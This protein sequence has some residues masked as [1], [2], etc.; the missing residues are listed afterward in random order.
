[1]RE[2]TPPPSLAEPTFPLN[3]ADW[4]AMPV[5]L[6]LGLAAQIALAGGR[7]T[8]RSPLWTD[9]IISEWLG[10]D[11][12]LRHMVG[13]LRAG[14]DTNTPAFHLLLRATTAVVRHLER[15]RSPVG[16]FAL[17]A[18]LGPLGSLSDDS[19]RILP[20]SSSDDDGSRL[21]APSCSQ[22]CF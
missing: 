21:V 6:A 4:V 14:I 8:L 5:L 22:V 1:M 20:S 7:V 10:T 11:P 3:L 13:A 16:S 18:S 9:E 15:D 2:E 17:F 12:S 19:A